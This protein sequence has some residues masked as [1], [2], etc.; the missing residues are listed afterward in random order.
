MS[1]AGR[2]TSRGAATMPAALARPDRRQLL[3]GGAMLAATAATVA[4]KPR[5]QVARL[6]PGTL[7][8][9]IPTT[10]GRWQFVTASGL[11]V[12][13]QDELTDQI[14][15]QVLTRVYGGEGLPGIMLLI[16]YGSSQDYT[17]Q[18]HLPEVCYPSSGYT[19]RGIDRVPVVLRRGR[20]E[21]ATFL[22]AERSDRTEQVFYW[23]RIGD[24]FPATLGQERIAVTLANLRGVL[25]DGVLVRISTLG[26][27][28]TAA[29][30]Q[31]EQF[32]QSLIASLRPPGRK[33]LGTNI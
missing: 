12:P 19:I 24:R 2:L 22:T 1:D 14:Y 6:A 11:V 5:R 18:A 7:D 15:D 4:L 20:S 26:D 30:A 3:I 8:R 32:N 29:L 25:P 10:I 23:V 28:R 9:A 17:L 13:P 33:L 31:I 27:D 16:A 21:V